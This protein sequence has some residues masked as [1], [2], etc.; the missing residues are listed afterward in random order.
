MAAL[1]GIIRLRCQTEDGRQLVVRCHCLSVLQL[2]RAGGHHSGVELQALGDGNEITTGYAGLH[3]LLAHNLAAALIFGSVFDDEDRIT[4][5]RIQDGR[6]G[7]GQHRLRIGQHHVHFNEHARQQT[8]ARIAQLRLNLHVAG[9]F[10]HAGVDGSD[11]AFQIQ[12]G[13]IGGIHPHAEAGLQP[14]QIPLRQGKIH[15]DRIELLQGDNGIAVAQIL[16]DAHLAHAQS[17]CKRRAQGF[18]RHLRLDVLHLRVGLLG[19]CRR[20]IEIRCRHAV[21]LDHALSAQQIASGQFGGGLGRA[22]RGLLDGNILLHQQVAF[23]HGGAR[24]KRQ[25]RNF[26]RQFSLH[27]DA[28]FRLHGAHRVH[29]RFPLQF[30]RAGIGHHQRGWL[31]IFAGFHHGIELHELDAGQHADGNRN[32]QQ[33]EECVLFHADSRVEKIQPVRAAG[34]ERLAILA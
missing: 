23:F 28:I 11:G 32:T 14:R 16:T 4:I 33:S 24:C 29:Q 30:L 25:L 18:F 12:L 15:H 9:R 19:L 13:K 17:S 8:F 7:N 22:Q 34:G 20:R 3:D 26:A 10:F 1:A 31:I 5:G 21:L 6:R 27:H 2:E